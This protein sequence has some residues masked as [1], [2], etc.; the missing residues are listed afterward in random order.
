M[1]HINQTQQCEL[2][3]Q[4]SKMLFTSSRVLKYCDV[5]PLWFEDTPLMDWK[6]EV[7]SPVVVNI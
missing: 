2:L 1:L 7:F 3:L 6:Y 5:I 4:Y